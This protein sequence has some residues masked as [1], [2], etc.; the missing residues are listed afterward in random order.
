MSC[1]DKIGTRNV[2]LGQNQDKS[3]SRK[4]VGTPTKIGMVDNYNPDFFSNVLALA[5]TLQLSRYVVRVWVRCFVFGCFV[6]LLF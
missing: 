5:T 1:Q 4:G 3:R 2:M 6:A